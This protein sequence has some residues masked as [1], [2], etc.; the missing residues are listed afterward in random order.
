MGEPNI[1]LNTI[2]AEAFSDACDELEKA[3]DFDLAVHN[4]IKRLAKEHQRIV[5]NGNGY[6]PE[7]AEEAKKRGLPIAD[8]MLDAIPALLSETSIE[9]F[10]KFGVFNKTEL[11]S[12]AEIEYEIYAKKRNIEAKTMIDIIRKQIIPATI[13]YTTVLADSVNQVRQATADADVSTQVEMLTEVSEYLKDTKEKLATLE[14]LEAQGVKISDSVERAFFYRDKV[15][16]AMEDLRRP[17]DKLEMLVD[18]SMWPM[19][20]Y[21]DMIFEV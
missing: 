20:S 18:K 8:N 7:W 10:A 17:V 3:E 21:G 4:L 11:E 6:S 14:T 15:L 12:R 1:V 16:V 9:L 19:P 13:R 2:V 5:F